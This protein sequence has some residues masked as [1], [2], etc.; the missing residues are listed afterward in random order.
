MITLIAEHPALS[1]LAAFLLGYTIKWLLDLFVLRERLFTAEARAKRR[2][3]E[4][5]SE[6]FAHSRVQN[7]LKTRTTEC[8]THRKARELAET[9]NATLRTQLAALTAEA[10]QAK[11]RIAGL[12]E[13]LTAAWM[14]RTGAE[15][16]IREHTAAATDLSLKLAERDAELATAHAALTHLSAETQRLSEIAD[17]AARRVPQLES[18]LA[19]EAGT[20]AALKSDLDAA[21]RGQA[22]AQ[23]A[24]GDARTALAAT[25]AALEAARKSKS[26]AEEQL[27]TASAET[28]AR[29]AELTTLRQQLAKLQTQLSDIKSDSGPLEQRLKARQ[30]E[31]KQLT[32]QLGEATEEVA[33]LKL[34]AAQ[35]EA[36]LEASSE[37]R[38]TLVRENAQRE[39][40]LAL[41]AE[42]TAELEAELKAISEAHAQL[43]SDLDSRIANAVA[44][45]V[46][47]VEAAAPAP[48]P[49]P[50]TPPPSS[51]ASTEA[52][53]AELD[54]MSRER[55]ELAAE[56]ATLRAA[57]PAKPA[58]APGTKRTKK[59]KPA[60]PAEVSLSLLPES[61]PA[62]EPAATP[63]PV[64]T[65]T[66]APET[67][68]HELPIFDGPIESE[69]AT[70]AEPEPEPKPEPEPEL[71]HEPASAPAAHEPA[72]AGL[73]SPCP[74]PLSE[75]KGIDAVLE[76]R[77]YA[78]GIG[79]FWS[80][81]QLSD[82]ELVSVLELGELERAAV[83][84]EDI[85]HDA[86]R[87]ARDTHSVGRTWNGAQPDDLELI[88]GISAAQERRLYEAGICT[89]EALAS[90]PLETLAEV[91]P[92]HGTQPPDYG[93]WIAKARLLGSARES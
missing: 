26:E 16:E 7:D 17:F 81:A 89:F 39:R 87:L 2:G 29:A 25:H 58:R 68:T 22:D 86:A 51:S 3:E 46:A 37:T 83:D 53:L 57:A 30:E 34:R 8:E 66:P 92:G 73:V 1:V 23:S 75:V 67:A 27:K 91:C 64:L 45:A 84:F 13:E 21:L 49:A 19:S 43:Q 74:Q 11:V 78:W 31:V 79:S 40:E 76:Q 72:P 62:P 9:A 63:A 6:R 41:Q 12:E 52:L 44:L 20:A 24:A 65:P 82:D 59:E 90:T 56:L 33:A 47:A 15:G 48:A 50:V 28:E 42:K 85:R 38:S 54:Q 60:P 10:K 35:A 77:L 4:L 61:T 71:V 93:H 70:A 14:A 80:L 32:T 69:P 5:D 55:N 36:N 18:A 88:E